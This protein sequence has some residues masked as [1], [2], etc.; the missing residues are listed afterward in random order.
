MS[1]EQSGYYDTWGG[2][3]GIGLMA[4]LAILALLDALINDMLPVKYRFKFPLKCRHLIFFMLAGSQLGLIYNSV[5]NGTYD[6]LLLKYA[7]DGIISVVVVFA[8]FSA[9]HRR[10]TLKGTE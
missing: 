3:L 1:F 8:D 2:A 5:M 10:L 7:W 4:A 9:R 6:A